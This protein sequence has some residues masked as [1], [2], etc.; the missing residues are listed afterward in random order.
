MS[1]TIDQ[2]TR[3]FYLNPVT[4]GEDWNLAFTSSESIA[5]VTFNIVLRNSKE[6]QVIELNPAND[7]IY[8]SSAYVFNISV[9]G[10][11]TGALPRGVL[12]GDIMGTSSVETKRWASI[13]V[14]I[15]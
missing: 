9:E 13:V 5:N 15:R 12:R 14:E 1:V 2:N 4:R 11:A 3:T 7:T 8:H 6:Q 10:V